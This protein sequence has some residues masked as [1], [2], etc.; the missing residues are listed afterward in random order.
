MA[1]P[2]SGPCV[3]DDMCEGNGYYNFLSGS[4]IHMVKTTSTGPIPTQIGQT[5][6]LFCCV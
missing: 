2:F 6:L 3:D 4:D 5:C 1:K